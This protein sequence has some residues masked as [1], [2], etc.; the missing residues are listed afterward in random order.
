MPVDPTGTAPGVVP[1]KPR[2]KEPVNFKCRVAS[3][4]SITAYDESIPSVP[5]K[6]FVCTKCG[7]VVSINPGGAFNFF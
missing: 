3:C 6:R 4:D 7:N 2:E 1:D 5:A